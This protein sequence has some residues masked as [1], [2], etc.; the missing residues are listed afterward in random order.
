MV[1]LIA[2]V[3]DPFRMKNK[4][5]LKNLQNSEPTDLTEK[6]YDKLEISLSL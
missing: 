5:N 6:N 3:D 2:E 1:Q 4:S